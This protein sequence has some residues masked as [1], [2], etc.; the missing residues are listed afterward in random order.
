MPTS[1]VPASGWPKV[2]VFG[3]GA[4][5]CYFGA[6]LAM[7][8]AAVSL[9]ARGPHVQAIEQHG[10]IFEA[11]GTRTPVR[12]AASTRPDALDSADL[13]LFCVKS[14]VSTRAPA[15]CR[16][17]QAGRRGGQ[18]SK[19]GS[20]T[21]RGCGPLRTRCPGCGGLWACSMAGPGMCGMPAGRPGAGPPAGRWRY[22][23]V[24]SGRSAGSRPR[25]GR[26]R[27]RCSPRPVSAMCGSTYG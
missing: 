1:S 27:A 24:A 12:L 20:T 15:R 18:P 10:L 11:A 16:A 5:G 23:L 9:V 6:R 22:R 4:V 21:S 14:R 19:Q 3:A 13:V 17:A 8:G 2:W 25:G 26:L 7:A